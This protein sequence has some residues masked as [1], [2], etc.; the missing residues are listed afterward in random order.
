M[1][2]LNEGNDEFGRLHRRFA[3]FENVLVVLNDLD[4]YQCV[5][6]AEGITDNTATP[7]G[8][9]HVFWSAAGRPALFIARSKVARRDSAPTPIEKF[10][11]RP[12][13]SRFVFSTN[14]LHIMVEDQLPGPRILRIRK[15]NWVLVLVFLLLLSILLLILLLIFITPFDFT[16]PF[17]TSFT[18]YYI[19][20]VLYIYTY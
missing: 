14:P 11:T 17:T 5:W 19:Y 16:I 6:N 18:T 4:D 13:V 9:S 3:S 1:N 8:I 10:E 2:L 7:A 12:V 15:C 20:Y